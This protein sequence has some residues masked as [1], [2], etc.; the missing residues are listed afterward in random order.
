MQHRYATLP[1]TPDFVLSDP[2]GFNSPIAD[3][4]DAAASRDSPESESDDFDEKDDTSTAA[5][6]DARTVSLIGSRTSG[7]MLAQLTRAS[8]HRSSRSESSVLCSPDSSVATS[9][10][11]CSS[12]EQASWP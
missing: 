3:G 12:S 1:Q 4:A 5:A 10:R 9:S 6:A 8:V 7:R 11:Y 2:L